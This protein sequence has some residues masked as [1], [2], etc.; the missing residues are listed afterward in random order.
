MH[1]IIEEDESQTSVRS[2][3]FIFKISTLPIES[4]CIQPAGSIG[5]KTYV[6]TL[7]ESF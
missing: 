6:K 5:I 2:G 7:M 1:L 4:F 3:Y